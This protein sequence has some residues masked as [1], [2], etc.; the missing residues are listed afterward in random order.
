MTTEHA[1]PLRALAALLAYPEAETQAAIDEIGA[2]L[3][4]S[5]LLTGNDKDRLYPLLRRL[6]EDELIDLQEAYVS[7]FDRGRRTSLHL[8]EHLLGESRDRGAAMVDLMQTYERAGL[9][10]RDGELPDFLPALLE[11][12]SCIDGDGVQDCI[13]DCAH[14][15]R[16]LGEAVMTHRQDYAA[17]FECVL[18]IGRQKG[19]DWTCKPDIEAEDF[20]A[21]W[22]E[23]P[24][25]SPPVNTNT[26]A[27]P[28]EF[29]ARRTNTKEE[30]HG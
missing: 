22:Q 27:V 19:L 5:R 24:A 21:D 30:R 8:F 4:D 20:D 16:P 11:Y 10:M 23:Q 1:L 6:A 25:F 12:C 7:L 18:H 15:L 3:R 29:V 17:V 13:A 28:I 9:L 2:V 14:I 26:Q